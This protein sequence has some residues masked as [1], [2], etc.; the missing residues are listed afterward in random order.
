M[1]VVHQLMVMAYLG[2]EAASNDYANGV[3]NV[4]DDDAIIQF[5]DDPDDA[6]VT[7]DSKVDVGCHEAVMVQVE[8]FC[9]VRLDGCQKVLTLHREDCLVQ[10]Q[11]HYQLTITKR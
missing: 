3:A 5:L 6:R 9:A 7:D 2:Q 1:V 11:M 8:T 4:Q 10:V